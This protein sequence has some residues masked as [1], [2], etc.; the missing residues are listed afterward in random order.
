MRYML[1]LAAVLAGRHTFAR[2]VELVE[3]PTVECRARNGSHDP[4]FVE[5]D[6]EVLG[7]LPVRIEVVPQ[8]LNLLVPAGAQP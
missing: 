7:L 2:E 4:F 8:A 1:F 6:G 5:A 3:T